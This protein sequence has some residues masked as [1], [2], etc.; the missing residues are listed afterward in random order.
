MLSAVA[1]WQSQRSRTPVH[2]ADVGEN[3]QVGATKSTSALV[4]ERL[5]TATL[6]DEAPLLQLI[7]KSCLSGLD[8][9]H[10]ESRLSVIENG[11]AKPKQSESR[12]VEGFNDIVIDEPI[13]VENAGLVLISAYLERLFQAFNWLENSVFV[14][15]DSAD[16]ATML[17]VY[18][19]TGKRHA[20]EVDLT[21]NKVLCGLPANTYINTEVDLTDEIYATADSLLQAVIGHWRALGTTSIDGLRQSFLMRD[22][23]LNKQDER[24]LLNVKAQPFDMLLD[25]IPWAFKLIKHPWMPLPLVTQWRD[26]N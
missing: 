8:H 26:E 9:G 14:D 5:L 2:D 4:P 19:A 21:L 16:K 11:N 23:W 17:L 12:Q 25:Q 20:D 3:P 13:F 1:V 10:E 24:W 6:K 22:A 15:T 7:K 18:L